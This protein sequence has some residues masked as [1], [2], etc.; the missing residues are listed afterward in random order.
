ML[1]TLKKLAKALAGKGEKS[2]KQIEEAVRDEEINEEIEK[3][4]ALI[5]KSHEPVLFA[6]P[7]LFD[8]AANI[9]LLKGKI[10]AVPLESNARGV[11]L[12]GPGTEG[13]PYKEMISGGVK[14]LYAVG[15]IP[16]QKRPD[17]GFLIVQ[18]S[19]LTELAKQ[20]DIVFPSATFLESSGTIVDYLGRIKYLAQV[21]EP[22]GDAKSHRDIF[23]SLAN[24]L[25]KKIK[26]PTETEI[27]KAVKE[28]TKLSFSPFIRREGFEITPGD[29]IESINASVINGSRLLWLKETKEAAT[30]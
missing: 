9:A 4:A 6:S 14:V 28:K 15:E 27:K 18:N 25:G 11:A 20:A 26:Q 16:L 24:A 29:F 10:I 3:A 17:S 5:A 22:A 2:N 13:K 19:H 7:R 21:I 30:V 8:A 12:M 23:I 1:S